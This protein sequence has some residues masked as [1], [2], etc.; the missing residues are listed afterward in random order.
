MDGVARAGVLRS[1]EAL[2]A[3]DLVLVE[4]MVRKHFGSGDGPSATLE[5][6]D[7]RFFTEIAFGG[8]IGAGEAWMHGYWTCDDLVA[9][10][11]ILLRNRHVLEGMEGGLEATA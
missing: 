11:R 1:L 4:G 7:P 5:I 3:G 6:K 2:T 10:V 8:S 9:L